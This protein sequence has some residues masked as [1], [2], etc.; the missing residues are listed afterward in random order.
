MNVVEMI[1]VTS[2][3]SVNK[4]INNQDSSH[5]LP[6]PA[7]KSTIEI[8]FPISTRRLNLKPPFSSSQKLTTRMEE[9]PRYAPPLRE[10]VISVNTLVLL[11]ALPYIFKQPLA[12]Y[13]LTPTPL[14]PPQGDNRAPSPSRSYTGGC[15]LGC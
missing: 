1:A 4:E 7:T 8:A 13:L 12:L 2:P 9:Q 3:Q 6:L 15:L 5:P 10:G 11:L 14:P